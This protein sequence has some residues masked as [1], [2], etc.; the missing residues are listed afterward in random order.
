MP[1]SMNHKLESRLLGEISTI[2]DM[3]MMPPLWQKVKRKSLL[4]KVK[5]KTEKAGLK[6]NI[7]KMKVMASSPITLWQTDGETKETVRHFILRGSKITA[8]GDC[9]YEIKRR[10]LLGRKI[11][12]NLDSI[13]KSRDITFPA[14]VHLVKAII[15]L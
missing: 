9:S 14:K 1:G 6:L 8:D 11:M 5:E 12:T 4:L 15:F 2:S 3:Q 10:L 7:Q 13:F